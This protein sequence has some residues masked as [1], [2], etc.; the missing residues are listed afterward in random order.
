MQKKKNS[1]KETP[2]KTQ[3]QKKEKSSQKLTKKEK[4][5]FSEQNRIDMYPIDIYND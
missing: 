2:K 3:S 5:M 1:S 4:A